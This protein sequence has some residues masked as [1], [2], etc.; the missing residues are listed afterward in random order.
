M[1][2]AFDAIW[3]TGLLYKITLFKFPVYS[4]KTILSYLLIQTFEMS[5]HRATYT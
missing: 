4:V 1:A 5:F 3:V 2:N